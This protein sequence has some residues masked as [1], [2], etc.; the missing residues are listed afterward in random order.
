MTV[1]RLVVS[2]P[3]PANSLY[4]NVAKVGRVKTKKY[5]SWI[6]TA[7]GEYLA[8]RRSVSKVL[9]PYT[10]EIRVPKGMRGDVDNR[11]KASVDLLVHLEITEDDKHCQKVSI[12][13]D[14]ERV[15]FCEIIARAA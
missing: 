3:P 12:E 8:Q 15:E 6:K 1:A 10:V 7:E 9:G 4:R 11:I 5:K 13:R 14:P 2:I